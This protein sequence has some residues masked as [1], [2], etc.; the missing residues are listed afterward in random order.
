MKIERKKLL[1]HLEGVRCGGRVP[2]AL[3]TGAFSTVAKS[4][5]GVLIVEVDA[6][7]GAEDLEDEIGI[8]LGILTSALKAD[9]VAE[10][11]IG[12]SKRLFVGAGKINLAMVTT[13]RQ[14]TTTTVPDKVLKGVK[15]L[16]QVE[17][18]GYPLSPEAV[19]A[20]LDLQKIL[21]AATMAQIVL[22][23]ESGFRLGSG[24]EHQGQVTL[25]GVEVE[26]KSKRSVSAPALKAVL[27]QVGPDARIWFGVD[28][29][30]H[31]AVTIRDGA[32]TY[33]LA[34]VAEAE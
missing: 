1:E 30:P 16:A 19:K 25:A 12:F 11:E 2:E 32:H 4:E 28:P 7:E 10:V 5:D 21:S 31:S 34:H 26:D 24:T 33:Y 8:D 14:T 29:D 9:S 20:F 3:F 18:D 6:L 15:G 22:G 13:T 23:P 27:E 17:G